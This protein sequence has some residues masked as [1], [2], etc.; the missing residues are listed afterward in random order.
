MV[1]TTLQ[2]LTASAEAAPEAAA[3]L[4]PGRHVLTYA[5]LLRQIHEVA[6]ILRTAGIGPADRVAL[7][8]PQG[9]ELA[10]AFVAVS[11]SATC[12]PMNLAYRARE[13]EFFLSDLRVKALLA[14]AGVDSE[15][16]EVARTL[17]IAQLEL[18]PSPEAAGLFGLTI[19]PAGSKLTPATYS[20]PDD[21]AL[22][23]HTSGTTAKPKI[24]PLSHRNLSA[25]ALNIG[26][27]LRLGPTDRLLNVMPLFHIHGL[28]TL[29]ASL[30][31][32]ASVACPPAFDV[33]RFFEWMDEFRPT[34]YTAVPTIHRAILGRAGA[35]RAVIAR[36]PLRFIR[37]SSAPLPPR[38]ARELEEAFGAPV[39][40]AY[41]MTEAAHQI[42]T[43]PLPPGGRKIG[44]VGVPTGT[45][46]AV[47]D[48]A[49]QPLA[50]G[51]VGEIVIRGPSVV[52]GYERN[53]GAD[54]EA[55]IQGWFRTGDQ[56]R[57]D[58]D[59]SVFLTGRTKEIINRGG[60]KISPREVDDILVEH[61]A[62]AQ[63]ATFPVPHQTLGED[64]AAAVV[65]RP[66]A[67]AT[68]DEIRRFAQAKLADYKVPRE[69]LLVEEIPKGPTGKVQRLALATQ[70]DLAGRRPPPSSG[71]A[72]APTATEAALA[73]IWADVL[74]LERVE[75]GD[76]FFQ[77][78]GDSI[79]AAVVV[80][81]VADTLGA[82]LPLRSVFE[83]PTVRRLAVLVE[84][85]S[86][87]TEGPLDALVPVQRGGV[88]TPFFAGGSN[89]LYRDLA[90]HL[91]PDQPFF[92]LD[93]YT[94]QEER[95]RRGLAPL[96]R[97]EDIAAYFVDRLRALQSSGPY[98]IGGACEG[99]VVAFEV[100]QQ[101]AR[102]G[103]E[104]GLLLIWETLAPRY[105]RNRALWRVVQQ[106]RTLIQTGAIFR[107]GRM[108]LGELARHERVEYSIF[109]SVG[110]YEPQPYPGRVILIRAR[111]QPPRYQDPTV[112]WAELVTGGLE[113]RVV[114]G[115][116]VTYLRRHFGEF[117]AEVKTCVERAR[118]GA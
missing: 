84:G 106:I 74:Q 64:V 83:H 42:A 13:F 93:V 53:P 86:R 117:A 97:L 95:L 103:Q 80:S 69:I 68:G 21:T 73:S 60:Q 17:G 40:E 24:V 19:S 81:R 34:W 88:H 14:P 18:T 23:L 12:A 32:G 51:Q 109:R 56:G 98:L 113:T 72:T 33:A 76:N 102:A 49:G 2:L 31:A 15:A 10:A 9:P 16:V 115:N 6:H 116:H 114:P 107:L 85:A 50:A 78:G 70:L 36:R 47:L 3:I 90:E 11:A 104:I 59:G 25:S 66:Q 67:A 26:A 41:G 65:L 1:G 48:D 28:M 4:A 45:E 101:L 44:S 96:A 27:S 100:A 52:R 108:Q 22:I 20:G 89:P 61:P 35:S 57:V 82:R 91:G 43:N 105:Y 111:E 29:L 39:L 7:V 77:L 99:G 5:R 54:A 118:R 58:E 38:V 92:S 62:V 37:S 55:F 112:G 63:A 94:L 110:R 46:L 30:A 87:A 75:V 71:D 79:Q 8:I